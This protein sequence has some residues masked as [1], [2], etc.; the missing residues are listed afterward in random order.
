MEKLRFM[1]GQWVSDK[2]LVRDLETWQEIWQEI[3]RSDEILWEWKI[4]S[5]VVEG[6]ETV[7]LDIR[8]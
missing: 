2:I 5:G 1:M 7:K 8:E 6:I 4:R 3:Y